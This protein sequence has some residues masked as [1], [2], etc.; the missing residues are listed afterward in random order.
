MKNLYII[1]SHYAHVT[2]TILNLTIN[3]QKKI[4]GY[5]DLLQPPMTP[6]PHNHRKVTPQSLVASTN[7][8]SFL[9]LETLD[10]NSY[11][12]NL[13]HFYS[14]P[15]T[16]LSVSSSLFKCTHPQ[17]YLFSLIFILFFLFLSHHFETFFSRQTFNMFDLVLV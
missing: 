9:V 6:K 5:C 12:H 10:P 8:L 7:L 13:T 14:P 3:I 11:H 1:L 15:I 2:H 16:L 17:L 4:G